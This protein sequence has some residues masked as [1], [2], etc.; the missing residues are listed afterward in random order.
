MDKEPELHVVGEIKG[1]V[2]FDTDN[3]FCAYRIEKVSMT[4]SIESVA[5]ARCPLGYCFDPP[6]ASTPPASH[7]GSTGSVL[8][9]K[10]LGRRK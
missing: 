10:R 5:L 8:G 9:A 7:R 2:G 1:G 4:R 3:A 6:P